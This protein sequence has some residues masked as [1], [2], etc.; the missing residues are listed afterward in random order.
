MSLPSPAPIQ[1]PCRKVC[2]VEGATGLC[3]GC[4][5]TLREIAGWTRYTDA[6]RAAVMAALPERLARA[7]ASSTAT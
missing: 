3:V 1:S 4:G 6:E 7:T 5:R 2:A